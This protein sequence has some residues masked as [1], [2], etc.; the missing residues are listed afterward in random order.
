MDILFAT[1]KLG[2]ELSDPRRLQR[3]HGSARTKLIKRRLAGLRAA[4]TLADMRHLPGNCH[5]LS[6][7][8]DGQLAVSLDGP[9]RLVFEAANDPSPHLPDGGLDWARVTAIRILEVVNY[10]GR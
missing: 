9:Y 4:E 3:G 5:E 6:G 7:D 1:A 2:Q 10:H 8:R